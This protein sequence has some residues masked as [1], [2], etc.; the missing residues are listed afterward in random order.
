MKNLEFHFTVY[1]FVYFALLYDTFS[2]IDINLSQLEYLAARLDPFECRRLIAALHYTSYELPMNLAA[3]VHW[4]S[5]PNEGLGQSHEALVHRLRQLNRNDLADW[6]GK[7]TFK[8]LG[9]DME[10]IMNRS[11][12]KLSE[13]EIETYYPLTIDPIENP[14][15]DDFWSQLN[16]IL[17]AIMLGLMGTLLTLIGYIIFYI[18][19]VR[20]RRTKYR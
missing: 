18:I 1:L 4:N 20:L 12:D 15:N 14:G 13:Q 9:M 17:L 2:T 16:I 8:Q 11:F 5:S 19:K 7:S 10:R 3:A 6:L